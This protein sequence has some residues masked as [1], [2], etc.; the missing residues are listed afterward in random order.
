MLAKRVTAILLSFIFTFMLAS[1]VFASTGSTNYERYLD[2]D[3]QISMKLQ[4][5]SDVSESGKHQTLIEGRG[6]LQRYD[7]ITMGEDILRVMNESDWKAD[8]DSL[9]GLK[10]ASTFSFPE[11]DLD[12]AAPSLVYDEEPEQVFAV[13]I[14]ANRG[15]EGRLAQNISSAPQVVYEEEELNIYQEAYTSDGTVKRYIDFVDQESGEYIFEDTEIKGYALIIDKLG[16][17]GN[18][19]EEVGIIPVEQLESEQDKNVQGAEEEVENDTEITGWEDSEESRDSF[20]VLEGDETFETEVP[21]GT[22]L[23]EIGLPETIDLETDKTEANDIEIKWDQEIMKE[24]DPEVPGPF[25]FIGWLE[26]PDSFGIDEPV[27]IEYMVT[28]TE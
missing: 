5:G 21:L 16:P 14:D 23:E 7:F 19:P 3:G 25:M 12:D 13:S 8:P 18:G 20:L 6:K 4:S 10:V 27:L 17:D 24:Y 22:T 2:V 28:V 26:L 11:K 1:P 15:E 9:R